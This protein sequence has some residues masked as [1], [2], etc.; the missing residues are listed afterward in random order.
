MS[1][2]TIPA[3]LKGNLALSAIGRGND[4]VTDVPLEVYLLIFG[5]AAV[6]LI[7]CTVLFSKDETVTKNKVIWLQTIDVIMVLILVYGIFLLLAATGKYVI[8][9]TK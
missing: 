1:S 4:A 9:R 6:I 3:V 8:L 7:L 2:D 5:P